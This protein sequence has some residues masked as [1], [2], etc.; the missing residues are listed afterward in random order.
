MQALLYLS[1]RINAR[2]PVDPHLRSGMAPPFEEPPARLV[3]PRSSGT[4]ISL[5]APPIW[6]E[7]R[8]FST[9]ISEHAD[10]EHRGGVPIGTYLKTHLIE[11][12]RDAT[13]G[14]IIALGVRHPH[15]PKKKNRARLNID[16]G[17]RVGCLVGLRVGGGL[18]GVNVQINRL[19]QIKPR[20]LI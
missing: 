17:L 16:L 8:S 6:P 3:G 12:F 4:I 20:N 19:R 9:E 10:G 18:A 11:I 13:L 1:I 14:S 5:T 15:A 2:D 7:R